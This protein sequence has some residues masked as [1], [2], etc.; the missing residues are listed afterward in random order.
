MTTSLHLGLPCIA[1]QRSQK[2]V[3]VNEGLR[4]LDALTKLSIACAPLASEPGAPMELA[5]TSVIAYACDKTIQNVKEEGA[6]AP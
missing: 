1:P 2:H 6:I 3:T 5:N 4:R